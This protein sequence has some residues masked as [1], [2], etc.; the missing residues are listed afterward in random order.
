MITKIS[1]G[2]GNLSH[3]TNVTNA[4]IAGYESNG[5]SWTGEIIQ[6]GE[7]DFNS[8]ILTALNNG[9]DI[10]IRS[11]TGLTA[12]IASALANYPN[13]L[14]FVP[15]G[16]N[17]PGE[18]FES[19]GGINLPC[20]VVTGAGDIANETGDDIEFFSQDPITIEP[21]YSSYSNGYIAGQIAY[22]INT[23]NCSS[24]EAR[25]RAHVTGSKN[26]VWHETDGFGL[27][28]VPAALAFTG[29]IPDDP[30][31]NHIL[32][33]GD[34]SFSL[35]DLELTIV[36]DV[37][38]NAENY[39]IEQLIDGVWTVVTNQVTVEYGNVYRFRY[40]ANMTNGYEVLEETGYSETFLF[41]V[42]VLP[43]I[44][45]QSNNINWIGY[46]SHSC[47]I[48]YNDYKSGT[49]CLEIQST[50]EG[51]EYDDYCFLSNSYFRSLIR[52]KQYLINFWAR[53]GLSDT[54]ITVKIG[55][56]SKT[57]NTVSHTVE[58]FT[59]CNF[60]FTVDITELN[61]GIKLYLNQS[62]TVY[63]D[64]FTI[65]EAHDFSMG[66]W[67]KN[68][69]IQTTD[70]IIQLSNGSSSISFKYEIGTS[71]VIASI[72]D[73]E[74]RYEDESII[75][76]TWKLLSITG[77][78]DGSLKFY[79]NQSLIGTSVISSNVGLL[80]DFE[81][82]SSS[83]GLIHSISDLQ[84]VRDHI[85]DLN[86][87]K[88]IYNNGFKHKYNTGEVVLWND[89]KEENQRGKD[90]SLLKNNITLYNTPIYTS[91]LKNNIINNWKKITNGL[92]NIIYDESEETIKFEIDSTPN[93]VYIKQEIL[94]VKDKKY[95]FEI[96][97]KGSNSSTGY[98]INII[99]PNGLSLKSDL[100]FG[101]LDNI[102]VIPGTTYSKKAITF[103]ADSDGLFTIEI[104][105]NTV[106]SAS[107]SLW[108][109]NFSFTEGYDSTINIWVKN[110]SDLESNLLNYGGNNQLSIKKN[111]NNKFCIS[112]SGVGDYRLTDSVLTE[113]EYYLLSVI[114]IGG[115]KFPKDIQLY[116][117]GELNQGTFT[118]DLGNYIALGNPTKLCIA[119][120]NGTSNFFQGSIGEI[121]IL[122]GVNLTDTQIKELYNSRKDFNNTN[123]VLH[124]KPDVNGEDLSDKEN[125]VTIVNSPTFSTID[126]KIEDWNHFYNGNSKIDKNTDNA[127]STTCVNFKLDSNN[128]EVKVSQS[129]NLQSSKNYALEV[130]AKAD[131]VLSSYHINIKD[132][133]GLVLTEDNTWIEEESIIVVPGTSYSRK[134]IQFQVP[135]SGVYTI[136]LKSIGVASSNLY[137]DDL[138]L[139]F[140]GCLVEL[141]QSNITG[142]KWVDSS[143]NQL[144]FTNNS[145]LDLIS[146]NID[147]LNDL[148]I[149]SNNMSQ[150][151]KD[152]QPILIEGDKY[153]IIRFDGV[154]DVLIS[155]I[156]DLTDFSIF[157]LFKIR[158]S[159]TV[160][161][162][163]FGNTLDNLWINN[164]LQLGV[165]CS[166]FN[167]TINLQLTQDTL[168]I[169]GLVYDSTNN[170]LEIYQKENK[171]N[172]ISGIINGNNLL[173]C[174]GGLSNGTSCTS[175]DLVEIICTSDKMNDIQMQALV[176]SLKE[177]Y[178]ND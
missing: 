26:G 126:L 40:K 114:L 142:S 87:I 119:S 38:E 110:N 105:N 35:E 154:D 68:G 162:I 76:D 103:I 84:I 98:I 73:E 107:S 79:I 166:N 1:I 129:F 100:T 42:P 118:Q 122:K 133:N 170:Q 163:I 139:Y 148:S 113:D 136:E 95:T 128:S 8:Q 178:F 109:S 145:I 123:Q 149:N 78:R 77:D 115:A 86:G 3:D 41:N 9:S 161:S 16:A 157:I 29:T 60:Y 58:V 45:N 54:S 146:I 106:N 99:N 31:I 12:Y 97:T 160:K 66:I 19:N 93:R 36:C 6:L 151:T 89:F 34:I 125:D 83:E 111:T 11:T 13:I 130:W 48:S 116:L 39:I 81:S 167:N 24:W 169:L 15:A 27:I 104:S 22:I 88:D 155:N 5:A 152:N 44:I 124:I 174:L 137:F 177:Q 52:N 74:I 62:D 102:T 176:N 158:T 33:I 28:N 127:R 65:S 132:F 92:S 147:T 4:F 144:D 143:S 172:T 55:N 96:W 75:D 53:T 30:Y 61:Q 17:S 175:L 57:F 131:D 56:K 47:D 156:S 69:L 164:S 23:L 64:D 72:N 20:I 63:I 82:L 10:Y 71:C 32:E 117:N 94:L 37:V 85:W 43:T 141:L 91:I 90:L 168:E 67:V 7:G 51:D 153:N 108:F 121:E 50:R 59:E 140:E 171:I 21:D 135:I 80:K 25:Y 165:Y 46:N 101:V 70:K 112:N 173:S 134:F 120:N 2:G 159:P 150:D 138:S 18:I 49:S 14:C